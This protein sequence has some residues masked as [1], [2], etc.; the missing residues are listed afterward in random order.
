M[1]GIR[2]EMIDII[3]PVR[4]LE[5]EDYTSLARAEI[6]RCFETEEIPFVVGGTGI[7]VK[8]LIEG[9]SV[10]RVASARQSLRRDL[11]RSMTRDAY[12][13]L[14]R[15]DRNLA[16][17]IHAN[18]YEAIINALAS[19]MAPDGRAARRTEPGV[20]RLLLGIDPG[21][22]RVEARVVATY[23]DQVR[24]GLFDE[25]VELAYRYDLGRELH[26]RGPD[27]PNQVLHTHG[28]REYFEVAEERGKQVDRLDKRD[29]AEVRIRVLD[30]IQQYA[31]RQRSWFRK[32]PSARMVKNSQQALAII[33]KPVRSGR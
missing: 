11:P 10:D 19:V 29:L 2:H 7:Y 5:L 28:Y 16:D 6:A 24:R 30:H 25:V 17:R 26:W 4:K 20:R 27:S 33:A 22:D 23:D 12:A 13:M 31:R 15:L 9:W 3:E 21:R 14:R 32:M 18:N 8:A 1:Q